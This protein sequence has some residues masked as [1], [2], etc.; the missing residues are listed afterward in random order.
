MKK[1]QT[2]VC[3]ILAAV[4]ALAFT[5]CPGPDQS[6]PPPPPPPPTDFV[7]VGGGTF[8]MGSP[9]G[10]PNSQANE[11]PVRSVTVSGFY[12]SRFQVTQG[13]WYDV[14]GARPSWFT[15]V[16]WRNLPVEQVSWYDAIVFSNRLSIQSGLTPAYSIGGSTNPDDWGP[17]PY[18]DDWD[19][20]AI[21][22]AVEIV[23]GST[24]YRLPTEAQWEFAARG[25]IVCQ[26]NYT[27]SGSNTAADVAWY[28]DNS[29][30]RTHEVGTRQPNALGLY[31]MSGNVWEWVWDWFGPYPNAA[32]T[33]PTGPAASDAR[34]FRG[35]SWFS[36]PGNARSAFRDY[37]NPDF[38]FTAIGFRVVRP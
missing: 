28:R 22:D 2:V 17:V 29:G 31:D 20:L 16:N 30:N 24:G 27:F 4:L 10:T 14:M 38:R 35:G 11:R 26:G 32:Q 12:M 8:Q 3:G 18:W 15:G 23:P 37:V 13:E 25:G 33:N 21:W 19:I 7:R 9:E 36:A 34:V 6:P 1:R 5:A